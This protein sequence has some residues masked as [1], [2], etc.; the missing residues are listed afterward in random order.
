[1]EESIKRLLGIQGWIVYQV[2]EEADRTV[3][4]VGRPKKGARCER[5]GGLSFAVHQ[6]MRWRQVWHMAVG[7]RKVYLE[8]RARRYW[9]RNCQRAFTEGCKEIRKWGRRSHLAEALLL[10]ELREQ[11]FGVVERKSGLGYRALRGV[12]ERAKVDVA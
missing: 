9:C 8:I 3:V 6:R 11:S 10:G 2:R 5:C 4:R 1:M 12:V 7:G